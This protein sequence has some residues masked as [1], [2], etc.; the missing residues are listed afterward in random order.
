MLFFV[1]AIGRILPL[2]LLALLGIMGVNALQWLVSRKDKVERATGWGM[3]FVAAFILVLG[4]FTHDWWVYS[5][6]HTL[7]EAVTQEERFIGV[8]AER[9]GVAPPHAH[10]IPTGAGLFGLPLWLGNWALAGLWILPLAWYYRKKKK[11]YAL[12]PDG[13]EKK[14]ES[15]A[16]PLRAGMFLSLAMLIAVSVIWVLPDG[17]L[18]HTA[19]QE[20]MPPAQG[21]LP[22][23]MHA[24]EHGTALYHEEF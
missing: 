23:G 13:E 1:H 14:I 22:A 19:H 6:Q 8:V 5:G 20:G 21:R 24:D 12:L 9:I 11:E 17:F 18:N 7:L 15:R 16:M 2:I 10:G 4:L 3:I